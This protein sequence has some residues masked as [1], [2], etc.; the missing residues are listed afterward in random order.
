MK[1]VARAIQFEADERVRDNMKGSLKKY[2]Q[3]FA[4][5]A[6]IDP[7]HFARYPQYDPIGI[8]ANPDALPVK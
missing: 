1:T 4:I 8:R 2:L 6:L 5:R 3:D 7:N